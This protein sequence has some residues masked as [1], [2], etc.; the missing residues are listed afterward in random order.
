MDY[1]TFVF[2]FLGSLA[3]GLFANLQWVLAGIVLGIL[4]SIVY[5][6]LKPAKF[7]NILDHAAAIDEQLKKGQD[8]SD[9]AR[10]LLNSILKK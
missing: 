5:A 3:G 2:S 10:A 6:Y 8:L 1:I 7:K 4:I 9:S